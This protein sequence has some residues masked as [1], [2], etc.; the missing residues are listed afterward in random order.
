MLIPF[1]QTKALENQ[2]DDFLDTIVRGSMAMKQ[3]IVAYL[4][5]N[6]EEFE[7][8]IEMV[9]ELESKADGIRKQTETALYTYS[10]IPES[11][12]DVL[13]LLETMDNVIDRAKLV[14]QS[15]DVQ[16]PKI[17]AEY[18][19]AFLAVT[20]NSILA[21]ESVVAA[22]RCYFREAHQVR[23]H[24]NKVDFYESEADRTGL[25][26]KK[27]IFSST[28]LELAQKLHLRYFAER[29]ESISDIAEDVGERLAIATIK[30]SI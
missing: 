28:E 15:I 21:V 25:K 14:L 13:G 8:R 27:L 30:R 12:G 29:I 24:I 6:Q 18:R 5:G 17:P 4:E 2:V 16:Q 26:L 11:R 7:N 22:A 9:G 3:A 20:D 10:L 19:E 23:A 1:G